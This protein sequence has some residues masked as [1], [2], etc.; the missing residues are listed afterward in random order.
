MTIN[1]PAQTP[2]QI[3]AAGDL[4]LTHLGKLILAPIEPT[5]LKGRL[6]GVEHEYR[7]LTDQPVTKVRMRLEGSKAWVNATLD[8]EAL[9][10]VLHRG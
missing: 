5:A 9:V 10:E 8:P 4:S 6:I 2:R 3:I 7:I 1:L